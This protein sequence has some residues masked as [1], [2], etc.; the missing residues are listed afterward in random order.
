MKETIGGIVVDYPETM[1]IGEAAL[2]VDHG[3]S[4]YGNRL[5]GI[6]I[7]IPADDENDVELY[8]DVDPVPFQRLRRITGKPTE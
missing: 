3:K 8:Y 5:R 4:K 7:K 1:D 6:E 2:Y